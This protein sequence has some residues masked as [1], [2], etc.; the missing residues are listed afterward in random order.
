MRKPPRASGAILAAEGLAIVYGGSTL[1]SMG[2]L[3]D[4]ALDAGGKVTGVIPRFMDD[5]EWGHRSLAKLH[6]VDDMHE[7]KRLMLKLSDAV[8]AL[9][10]GCGT[11][12]EL[13]EA[14]TWKRLGLYLGPIVLVNVNR[15]FDPCLEL[16]SRCVDEHFM[17]ARH[18]AMWSAVAEPEEVAAALRAAPE[19]SSARAF[20]ALR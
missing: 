6:V 18:R 3:A 12:E 13:F 1:G 19:W 17:D 9:P 2:R 10:G 15:F 4:A 20:A 7:R 5:L 11:L 8:V 16:L 14:I